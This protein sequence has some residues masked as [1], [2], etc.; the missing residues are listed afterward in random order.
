MLVGLVRGLGK[1]FST[2]VEVEYLAVEKGDETS[3]EKFL[4]TFAQEQA[5]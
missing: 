5:A 1:R 4:V 3:A 2:P